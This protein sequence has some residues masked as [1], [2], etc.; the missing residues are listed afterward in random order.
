M[1]QTLG[2][3]WFG[4]CKGLQPPRSETSIGALIKTWRASGPSA[5]CWTMEALFLA[6]KAMR[7]MLGFY[8]FG[9]CKELQPSRSETSIGALIKTWR[10]S[11]PSAP[12]WTMEALFL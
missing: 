11:G 7:Q 9:G 12:C 6:Q 3:Y 8:W 10:A 5:P 2:L 4:G 1:R